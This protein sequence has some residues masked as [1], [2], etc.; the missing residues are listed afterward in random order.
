MTSERAYGRLK[1]KVALV[2]GAGPNIG[3]TCAH[4][5]AREGARIAVT[6]SKIETAEETV[7][8][9]GAHSFESI[10]IAGDASE[11]P[12]VMKAVA[13][14]IEHFGRLDTMVYVAGR[15]YRQEI[16][17]F[18]LD[19]WNLEMKGY[20][21][22]AMLATKHAARAMTANRAGSIIYILSDAAHQGEPGNSCYCAAKAGALNFAR[23]AAMEF[24][25][26][27]VR[28]NSVSPTFMEQ[29]YWMFPPEFLNP[30]RGPYNLT[31]DDF[32]QGIP[33]ARM[34]TA[35]DVANAVVFLASEESSYLTAVDIPLDGGAAAKYWP[36]TPGK[37]SGISSEN[38]AAGLQKNR[39]G[40]PDDAK[41]KG[42]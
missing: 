6:S 41:S 22:G 38:Y 23:A 1:D 11:E 36:W 27:G 13:R 5:M 25:Q 42:E 34:C 16:M 18:D 35:D 14:T 8:F 33:L 29:N 31:A 37:F 3:G 2:F 32:L 26:Y 28:V 21:T 19:V 4:F 9:L 15:Q 17:N 30:E 7:R 39:Y 40:E 20:L 12:D 24:A 10:A